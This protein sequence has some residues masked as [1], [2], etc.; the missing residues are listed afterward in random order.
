MHKKETLKS[1]FQKV[2]NMA[3]SRPTPPPAS[4]SNAKIAPNPPARSVGPSQALPSL[5]PNSS[6]PTQMNVN[7]RT[8]DIHL[9]TKS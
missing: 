1:F 8:Y 2:E 3:S 9:I 6:T 4:T 5:N 7:S